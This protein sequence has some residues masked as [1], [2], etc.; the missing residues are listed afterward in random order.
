MLSF[1]QFGFFKQIESFQEDIGESQIPMPRNLKRPPALYKVMASLPR[2]SHTA[3]AWTPSV[4]PKGKEMR[5]S[6]FTL[7]CWGAFFFQMNEQTP[8]KPPRHSF[9][10]ASPMT[11][12]E[13]F[14]LGQMS[15][16][17]RLEP[18]WEWP[19]L[20]SLGKD[21]RVPAFLVILVRFHQSFN[22]TTHI[23]DNPPKICSKHLWSLY[24]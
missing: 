17:L 6:D 14:L 21:L 4:T 8:H 15:S 12:A 1:G 5:C 11:E 24:I 2:G 18:S 16:K 13:I 23:H 9:I 19:M 7:G 20:Q 10:Y 22:R 3:R